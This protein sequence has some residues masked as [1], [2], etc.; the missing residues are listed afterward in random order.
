MKVSQKYKE[1]FRLAKMLKDA[2]IPFDFYEMTP[3][4]KK[5]IP[6]WE[7]YHIN[8]PSQDDWTISV[9]EGF[10]SYGEQDDKLELMG[11]LTPDELEENDVIGWLTAEEAFERIEKIERSK[12]KKMRK[13]K[14]VKI[15]ENT[16][17]LTEVEI[18]VPEEE[19]KTEPS[20]DKIKT[21]EDFTDALREALGCT[22]DEFYNKYRTWKIAEED[23]KKIYEPF[24]TKLIELHKNQEWPSSV[25]IGGAKLTYVSPSTRTTIDSK[26]LKEEEPEIAKKFTKTTNV[27]ASVRIEDTFQV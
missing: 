4:A 14:I 18:D 20:E 3:K 12:N 2:K 5:F 25:I 19:I 26:K 11:G 22:T 8:Y 6:E 15:N 13:K 21:L 23:F 10:G 16:L 27:S 9:I 1:I 24:K 7:H 17:E